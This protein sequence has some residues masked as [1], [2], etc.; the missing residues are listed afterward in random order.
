MATIITK[1]G[2]GSAVPPSLTQGELAIN[3][4]SGTLYY[5]SGSSNAV[6]TI[7]ASLALSASYLIGGGGAGTP[8]GANTTIQFN[9]AGTF[10]GSGNFTF[11]KTTNAVSLTG[12]LLATQS[13][14]SK[15]DYV[16]WSL[17]TTAQAPAHSEGRVHW[18]D[19]AKTL[20]IDT[21]VNNFMIEVG[22]MNVV[23]V[24]NKTGAPLATGK[25]VYI[26][27]SQ[28]NRPTVVTASW[29]SDMTSAA[30]LGFVAQTIN[31]NNNGYVVTSGLLRNIDTNA[32]PVGTQLYLSSS[33]DWTSTI[34]VSPK[35]EVRLGKVITQNSTTGIIY[36]DVMNGYE[37]GELHDV[38]ITTPSNGQALVYSSSLW[39]NQSIPRILKKENITFASSSWVSQSLY[40]YTYTDTDIAASSSIVDFTP[41]TASFTTVVNAIVYPTVVV[42]TGTAS[43]FATN[44]PAANIVGEL[45]ITN[46]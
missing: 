25:V 36:V 20:D 4:D 18:S 13:F 3:V 41:N 15:V 14:I 40:V 31:D 12:S 6:R 2:S 28:G 19:D 38:L 39:V 35:H 5:G 9:D 45:V 17:L 10:S 33:G 16:D 43:F 8:G 26:S 11:N 22:H 37:L 1:N 29:D 24:V 7:T 23:R 27:G 34:P 46:I 42:T 44:Q 32:Y 21:D 30:T